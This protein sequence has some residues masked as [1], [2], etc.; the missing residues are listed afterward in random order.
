MVKK[1]RL[2][3]YR[4]FLQHCSRQYWMGSINYQAI[5][6]LSTCSKQCVNCCR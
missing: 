4:S 1:T 5:Y 2:L 6:A 3:N